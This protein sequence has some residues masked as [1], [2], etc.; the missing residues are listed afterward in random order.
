MTDRV[1]Q[2]SV[3]EELVNSLTHGVGVLLSIAGLALLMVRAMAEYDALCTASVSVFGVTLLLMY[4]ASTLYHG[5]PQPRAKRWLRVCDHCAIYLLI[6]GTYTPFALVSMRGPWGWSLFGVVWA[7]AAAGCTFKVLSSKGYDNRRWH[8]LSSAL[9]VAMGWIVV[10][11]LRPA[12]Q[13]VPSGAM[14]LLLTGGLSYTGGVLFYM[15]DRLPYNHGIW[16]LFVLGGSVAH[17]LAVLFYVVP[18]AG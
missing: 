16:H 15:W 1:H 17:F 13:M 4:V 8:W 2:H 14:W 10:V 9:Y 12:L 3:G 5:L 7:M 11:A 18:A 6:A